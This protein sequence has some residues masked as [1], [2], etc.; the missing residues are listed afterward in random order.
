MNI[1]LWFASAYIK[2][3]ARFHMV[4]SGN[5]NKVDHQALPYLKVLSETHVLN[6]LHFLLQ[7]TNECA[8]TKSLFY[9]LSQKINP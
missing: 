8:S 9:N 6:I 3:F 7:I 1:D 5:M 4:Q 2:K